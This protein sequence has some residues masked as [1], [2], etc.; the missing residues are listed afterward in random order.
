[1]HRNEAESL[2]QSA[3]FF[4]HLDQVIEWVRNKEFFDKAPSASEAERLLKADLS[5]FRHSK[6]PFSN[7]PQV[8]LGLEQEFKHEV[9]RLRTST[10]AGTSAA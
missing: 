7:M 5:S 3:G 8:R 1:M 6:T 9:E 2:K 10:E 4:L